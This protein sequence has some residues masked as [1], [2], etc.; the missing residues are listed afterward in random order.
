M[1]SF[2]VAVAKGLTTKKFK[3]AKALKI[4]IIWFFSSNHVHHWMVRWFRYSGFYFNFLLFGNIFFNNYW[5]QND[6]RI[7]QKLK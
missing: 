2:S 5:L 7:H 1:D 4:L 6:L 3:T